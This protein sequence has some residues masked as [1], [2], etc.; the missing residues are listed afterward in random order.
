MKIVDQLVGVT[1]SGQKSC[2]PYAV[3]AST[4]GCVM[5]AR[6]MAT[7]QRRGAARTGA[8]EWLNPLW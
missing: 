7:S 2:V 6:L 5:S 3:C 8:Q 4:K 1:A